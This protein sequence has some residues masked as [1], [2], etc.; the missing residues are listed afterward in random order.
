L[1]IH[2][3][4]KSEIL[5]AK[6]LH[7]ESTLAS[8]LVGW[9]QRCKNEKH[10]KLNWTLHLAVNNWG[11]FRSLLSDRLFDYGAIKCNECF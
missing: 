8:D 4:T 7:R 1:A 10:P 11:D 5:V 9:Y 3:R 2:D 6:A